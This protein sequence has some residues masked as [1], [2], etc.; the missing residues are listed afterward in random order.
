MTKPSELDP[1][2]LGQDYNFHGHRPGESVK[3]SV[4]DLVPTGGLVNSKRDLEALGHYYKADGRMISN[5]NDPVLG[6]LYTLTDPLG[7]QSP[8]I[9]PNYESKAVKVARGFQTM[10]LNP[11][12]NDIYYVDTL[13]RLC[14]LTVASGYTSAQ[15]V[16][17]GISGIAF[18][19]TRTFKCLSSTG[20]CVVIN[21]SNSAERTILASLAPAFAGAYSLS[22]GFDYVCVG[23]KIWK[24]DDNTI[25]EYAR[26]SNLVY[27]FAKAADRLFYVPK[28]DEYSIFEIVDTVNAYESASGLNE[29]SCF[30]AINDTLISFQP[31][32]AG[33]SAEIST[34]NVVEYSSSKTTVYDSKLAYLIPLTET[35]FI[36]TYTND[37]GRSYHGVYTQSRGLETEY[38]VQVDPAG[39]DAGAQFVHTGTSFFVNGGTDT[40][41]NGYIFRSMFQPADPSLMQLPSMGSFD[42]YTFTYLRRG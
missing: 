16:E 14:K 23:D 8:S 24:V 25:T 21:H 42:G 35:A 10:S 9:I 29:I 3:I 13:D 39:V 11:N 7:V 32:G 36:L 1:Y 17:T 34:F 27:F 38:D 19:A 37:S 22:D 5:A 41:G 2:V 30:S 40:N 6:A 28:N 15:L 18:T 4:D 33:S 12:D 31:S 26:T 20:D